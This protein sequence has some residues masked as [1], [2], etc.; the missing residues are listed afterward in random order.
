MRLRSTLLTL[1]AAAAGCLGALAP[2]GPASAATTAGLQ[3][4]VDSSPADA[5]KVTLT[6]QGTAPC[7]VV[8]TAVG[9]IALT[10]VE[11]GGKRIEPT[12]IFPSYT[13]DLGYLLAQQLKTLAPG[14]SVTLPLTM[15]PAGA[16]GHALQTVSWSALATIGAQ[17]PIDTSKALSLVA[18]YQSPVAV[19][20][21]APLC[22]A[23]SSAPVAGAGPA[24]WVIW[25]V[26]AIVW[27]GLAAAGVITLLIL[28]RRRRRRATAAAAL[29]LA[30]V[31]GVLTAGWGAKPASAT[32][33]G[34]A[35]VTSALAGCVTAFGAPGGDPRNILPT[36]KDPSV[37][38]TVNLDSGGANGEN[39]FDPNNIFIYWSPDDTR[40]FVD[41]VARFPCDEL[42]HELYHAFEDTTPKGVDSH[43]CIT[44][45]GVH[46]GIAIKEVNATRAEN[47]RRA[48]QGRA[49][50][51]Y[52]GNNKLPDRR[53]PAAG[54][55][56]PA[57]PPDVR[58]PQATGEAAG[59]RPRRP[60]HHH[61]RRAALR[62]HGRR[63]VRRGARR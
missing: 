47:A 62:L 27:A 38:V 26:L 20:T 22:V 35:G 37:H 15:V 23:G 41:G 50:R 21:G 63:R 18:S 9:T 29:A 14:Q 7:Q 11:Q 61:L 12:A 45:G 6:N 1:A 3:V 42:Y 44:A 34:G 39:R 57:V 48:A 46:S 31:A 32:I 43:E 5:P 56:H 2:T 28:S 54:Q 60:A 49:Q 17:Y 40:P 52:Y 4:T 24:G 10:D 25:V 59:Q 58:L 55:G 53:L 8:A 13:D 30:L 51:G 36:L 16:T 33:S 19:T